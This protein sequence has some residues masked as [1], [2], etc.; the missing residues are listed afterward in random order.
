VR[1]VS[2]A[3]RAERLSHLTLLHRSPTTSASVEGATL[4]VAA[5]A[6]LLGVHANTVR[7]WTDQGRLPCLRINERGDRRYSVDEL[8]R[9]LAKAH[10]PSASGAALGIIGDVAALTVAD[11]RPGRLVPAVAGLLCDRLG[12]DA[13]L[14]VSRDGTQHRLHG[15]S[16]LDR[17]AVEAAR[18]ASLVAR[19]VAAHGRRTV[20]LAAGIVHGDV[21]QL[22]GPAHGRLEPEIETTLL[23]GV[24]GVLRS[25]AVGSRRREEA[26]AERQRA[27]TLLSVASEIGAHL[28][29]PAV[30]DK[31]LEQA[32][33]MFDADHAAVF[34]RRPSAL[35]GA[36]AV[37]NLSADFVH[38]VETADRL[39]LMSAAY[40]AGRTV[41][42][43]NWADDPRSEPLTSALR[44]EGINTIT[45]APLRAEE[46]QIGV[47]ALYHDRPYTWRANDLALFEQVARQSSAAL[48]NAR[49][50]ERMATWAAQL[51]AIQQL[52]VRMNGLAEMREIG[53]AITAE[54]HQLIDYHNVRVYRVEG[55]DVV[56][57]AWRGKIG[58]YE[59]EDDEQLRTKLGR[60]IT[61]WVVEHGV[62]QN[63]GDAA[64]DPRAM[65]IPG[66]EADLDESMLLAPMRHDEHVIGVIVLSKLGLHQ[67]TDDD[68][69]LLEIFAAMAAQAM[70]NAEATARLRQQSATLTRQLASQRELL[71]VTESI[72]G[73]LDTRALMEQIADRLQAL[74]P[75][76]NLGVDLFD[77]RSGLLTPLFARG[78]HAAQY[79]AGPRPISWGLGGIV[80]RSG[81]AEL[82]HDRL[83]DGRV[84]FFE[85]IGP[86][87]GAMI[88]VPLRSRDRVAGL[89][90]MERLGDGADFSDEEF[91]LAK[92]FAGHVS[93]A[94]RNAEAH[95]AVELRAQTD[96]LTGLLN[97]GAL[98]DRLA[99]V[100]ARDEPYSLLML[101]LDD[102]K[103]YNDRLGHQAGDAMLNRLGQVLRTACRDSDSVFRYGG[104]EFALLLPHTVEAGALAVADKV[105]RAVRDATTGLRGS[106][107]LSCSIGVASFPTDGADAAA[108]LLA[109]DRACYLAKRD[110]RDRIA[111]AAEG[112]ALAGEFLPPPPTPVDELGIAAA[113]AA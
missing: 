105:L 15:K 104:D 101:D 92:L 48:G 62:A 61:G 65:T 2:L 113:S 64:K 49:T 71:R 3:L 14:L 94:L 57:I 93:I 23:A 56:P 16:T 89:L 22:Q 10:G 102:F 36:D 42:R 96:A 24:A 18:V 84:A 47:L 74:I 95:H 83:A 69:R 39:P 35:V 13:A 46:Q 40:D 111:T 80:V 109:A 73:T 11:D 25:A 19:T 86:Q 44:A 32:V 112:L 72:L 38:A 41:S 97:H 21:L 53:H 17:Q 37:R 98:T 106:V 12:F 108:M 51:A 50:Y 20:A 88:F 54:L 55:E 99:E 8:Q 29:L 27:E 4:N 87:P 77:E 91:E 79:L 68:L 6:R 90:T 31:L 110:G 63:L 81:E 26:D 67:F 30:L 60:G 7:A 70:A 52:G 82:V 5:A 85:D 9:F 100:T 34:S 33:V 78:P 58:E 76:D 59:D 75:V 45:V 107:P 103:L 66:T 1:F 43:V 28:D